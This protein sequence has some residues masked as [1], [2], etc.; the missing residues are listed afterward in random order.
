MPWRVSAALDDRVGKKLST[1]RAHCPEGSPGRRPVA[2]AFE[3][4]GQFLPNFLDRSDDVV[5]LL[6]DRA[7]VEGALVFKRSYDVPHHVA[8]RFRHLEAEAEPKR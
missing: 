4:R 5:R 8:F 6:V 1:C 7:N 2:D 3:T